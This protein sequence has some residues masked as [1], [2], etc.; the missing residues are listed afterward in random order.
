MLIRGLARLRF[1][2]GI[3]LKFP[4]K[5]ALTFVAYLAAFTVEFGPLILRSIFTP[6]FELATGPPSSEGLRERR[7]RARDV[8]VLG[9]VDAKREAVEM[10][11][12]GRGEP[13]P[14]V[15]LAGEQAGANDEGVE[16]PPKEAGEAAVAV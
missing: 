4:P 14:Q 6:V 16:Q 12:A 15:A 5:V 2:I 11:K 7:A 10:L 8:Y 13:S 9:D 3:F 1:G